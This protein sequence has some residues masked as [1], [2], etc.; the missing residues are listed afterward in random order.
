LPEEKR[1]EFLRK[2]GLYAKKIDQWVENPYLLFN[3]KVV[4]IDEHKELQRE[5]SRL[6]DKIE[7]CQQVI[8]EGANLLL[9]KKKL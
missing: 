1:G 4:S 9:L 3:G 7:K 5:N 2:E 8:S 6:K